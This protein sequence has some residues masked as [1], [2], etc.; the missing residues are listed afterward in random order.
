MASQIARI[1][2]P[3]VAR[4]TIAKA[5]DLRLRDARAKTDRI[6][7]QTLARLRAQGY[8]TSVWV[9]DEDTRAL[10]RRLSRRQSLVRQRTRHK[11]EVH[12][13]LTRNLVGRAPVSDVFGKAGRAWLATVELPDDECDMVASCLRH[14]ELLE[15]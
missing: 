7:A 14:I 13:V 10:R 3:H 1:L 15:Q 2:A 4:V 9:A 5:Q 11:N 12:S 6:D 8:L